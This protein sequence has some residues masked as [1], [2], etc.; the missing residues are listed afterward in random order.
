VEEPTGAKLPAGHTG[1]VTDELPT[2]TTDA[3]ASVTAIAFPVPEHG[4]V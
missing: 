2:M 1:H 3:E 4:S